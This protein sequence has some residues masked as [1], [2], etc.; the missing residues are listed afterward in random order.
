MSSKR[1]NLPVQ[2]PVSVM[3]EAIEDSVAQ[4]VEL[5]L[6]WLPKWQPSTGMTRNR[7]CGKCIGSPL[8]QAAGIENWVPHGVQHA[9]IMRLKKIIDARIDRYIEQNL[10]MMHGELLYDETRRK[11]LPYRPAD[12][13]D[14]EYQGL[15]LDP[16]SDPEQPFLFTLTELADQLASEVPQA[17]PRTITPEHRAALIREIELSDQESRRIGNE[18]CMVLLTYQPVIK[19]AVD[20]QIEPQIAELLAELSNELSAP[21]F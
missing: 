15:E 10:P 6:R 4:A 9:L 7:V 18:I 8:A 21:P 2:Y 14:P 20:E 16:P 12:G 5:W 17:P 1:L 19:T 13:L 11:K 3:E